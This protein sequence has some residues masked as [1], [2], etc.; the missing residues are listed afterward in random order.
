MALKPSLRRSATGWEKLRKTN[1]QGSP[2]PSRRPMRDSR[3]PP[4][5][6]RQTEP[7]L[8][9]EIDLNRDFVRFSITNGFLFTWILL[10]AVCGFSGGMTVFC[11]ALLHE[12]AHMGV[13]RLCGGRLSA[14]ELRMDGFRMETTLPPT[15]SYL[16]E[17]M[18][19]ASGAAANLLA[20]FLMVCI[21]AKSEYIYILGGANIAVGLFNLAPAGRFDGGKIVRLCA[22]YALGP[23]R[24]EFVAHLIS[25]LSA[26]AVLVC[27][28]L[29]FRASGRNPM[30]ALTTLYL[31]FLLGCDIIKTEERFSLRKRKRR[32]TYQ[33]VR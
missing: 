9:Q 8:L 29:L 24:G 22:E 16:R 14:L 18:C 13:V 15:T 25:G 28:G 6:S 10:F 23:K 12:L 4:K 17:V 3:N 31:S 19:L 20:G 1:G 7:R 33:C 2:L 26:L 30:V 32:K 21:F 27:G 11:C 5:Q